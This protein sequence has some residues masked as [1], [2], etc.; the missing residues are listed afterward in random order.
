VRAK[1]ALRDSIANSGFVD[2]RLPSEDRLASQLGVSR[3]TVREALRS[4]EEEGL[5]TRQ[6]GI[7]TRVNFHVAKETSLNRVVGFY[8]L[9]REAGYEPA[10]A[11]TQVAE[12]HARPDVA[13]RLGRGDKPSILA[14]ERLFLADGA[15]ALH[16]VEHVLA[17]TVI[18]PVLP[19][20]VPNSI[21]AFADAFCRAPIDH[22]VVEIIATKAGA[23]ISAHLN[24]EAGEP[25]LRLIETH[26]DVKGDPFLVS[27]I[28]VVDEY[29]RFTVVRRRN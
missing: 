4:L 7:G 12:G 26:Y 9:I 28:H 2:G 14:I 20:E 6:R 10:I 15:A 24:V 23:Q 16:L 13:R 19:A 17:D 22:T 18:R 25:V 3:P 11:W 1:E 5:I 27:L 29:L 21:F 8:D